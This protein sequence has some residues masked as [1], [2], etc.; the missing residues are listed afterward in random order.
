[1]TFLRHYNFFSALKAWTPLGMR[2]DLP[3]DSLQS[4]VVSAVSKLRIGNIAENHDKMLH[5]SSLL[6]SLVP[7]SFP[8][9]LKLD[10][11]F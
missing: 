5:I 6:L 7:L 9:Q 4:T 2:S 3:Q 10:I 8:F 11:L 1:M